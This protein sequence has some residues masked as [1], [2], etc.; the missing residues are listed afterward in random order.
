MYGITALGELLIDFTEHG[1]SA[2]GMRLFE[3]NPGGAVA[4]LVYAAARLGERVAFIG[5]VGNDMHGQFLKKFMQDGGVDTRGMVITDDV[6]TT[7]AF[8][9]LDNGE[10]AFSFARKPGADTCLRPDEL[11]EALLKITRILHI[12]SLSLCDEPVRAATHKAI[13]IAKKAGAIISYDPNYRASL[14][15][16]RDEA[17]EQMR[18]VLPFVDVMKLSDE[19]TVLLTDCQDPEEAL[20]HLSGFGIACVAVTMGAKGAMVRTKGETVHVPGFICEAVDTTGAGDAYFGGFLYSLLQSG[21]TL[22]ELSIDDAATFARFGNA[23]AALCIGKRGGM[24]AMPALE[25]VEALLQP[26]N[27]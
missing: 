23:V 6:F 24:P 1:L 13:D 7:L 9:A 10:R 21:R 8:V 22:S 15:R 27:R 26:N 19:E 25:Q 16:S 4:N 11:D 2:S 18:S 5:K 20:A 14:W 17:I 3:Q 12:G